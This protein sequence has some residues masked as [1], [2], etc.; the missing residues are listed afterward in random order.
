DRMKAMPKGTALSG[1]ENSEET[2]LIIGIKRQP[3]EISLAE[4]V[5]WVRGNLGN[6]FRAAINENRQLILNDTKGNRHISMLSRA[7][8]NFEAAQILGFDLPYYKLPFTLD[9]FAVDEQLPLSKE[10]WVNLGASEAV[11]EQR[12]GDDENDPGHHGM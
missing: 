8:V 12:Q 6:R 11:L 4:A 3:A 5:G 1:L 2:A 9:Y 10:I 7:V